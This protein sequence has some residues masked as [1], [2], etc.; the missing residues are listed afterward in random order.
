MLDFE[1]GGRNQRGLIRKITPV[2]A[3]T[4]A[5]VPAPVEPSEAQ[6]QVR[7]FVLYLFKQ[8]G[9]LSTKFFRSKAFCLSHDINEMLNFD[10]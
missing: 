1:I 8:S 6:L 10:S 2:T 4:S 9:E 5:P 7:Y 3:L